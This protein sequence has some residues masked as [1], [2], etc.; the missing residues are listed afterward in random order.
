VHSRGS[1]KPAAAAWSRPEPLL[2]NAQQP[3]SVGGLS[4]VRWSGVS[5]PILLVLLALPLTCLALLVGQV[6]VLALVLACLVAPFLA[7]TD[8][9]PTAAAIAT[10]PLSGLLDQYG[11]GVGGYKIVVVLCA[12]C[13]TA[14]ALAGWQTVKFSV[15]PLDLAV[16]GLFAVALMNIILLSQGGK[17]GLLQWYAGDYA[18]YIWARLTIFDL[19]RLW[20]AVFGFA[21]AGALGAL[22]GFWLYGSGLT[23]VSE[24]LVR[25]TLPGQ[26]T[27]AIGSMMLV[28][29]G[30]AL[31]LLIYERRVIM[32]ATLAAILAAA[33]GATILTFS[34]GA[35]VGM[36]AI[37]AAGLAM[38]Q[39]WRIRAASA[40]ASLV[41][42]GGVWT[43]IAGQAGLSSYV[44]RV[45]AITTL[46]YT[47][48]AQRNVLWSMG[49]SAFTSH[50]LFGIGI[51]NFDQPQFWYPLAYQ[52]AAP[53]S[54]FLYPQAA[55]SFYIGWASDAGVA[56]L[57]F[58]GVALLLTLRTLFRCNR[59]RKGPTATALSY[60]I[61]FGF[62]GYFVFLAS[63]PQQNSQLPY[64]MLALAGCLLASMANLDDS[65][66]QLSPG[67]VRARRTEDWVSASQG[68]AD[69]TPRSGETSSI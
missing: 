32:R 5:W 14:G 2:A 48:T 43:G 57:I 31:P 68:T 25:L 24:Q 6:S 51:G 66:S 4:P 53:R 10:L 22:A 9:A 7:R 69:P 38:S 8:G 46:N 27:N 65:A 60:S 45:T 40:V 23:P 34:R 50:W 1:R 3:R 35:F 29:A 39:S 41:A 17:S 33:V 58:L 52:F 54:F 11:A 19:R 21:A 55:H 59:L 42:V 15:A 12:A 18:L 62:V 20:W 47:T 49:W 56:S 26:N 28:S 61:F 64:L 37:V 44:A 30:F 16:S 63:S 36:A 13:W 67:S